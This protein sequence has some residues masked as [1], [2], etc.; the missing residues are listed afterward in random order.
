MTDDHY[1]QLAFQMY[2]YRIKLSIGFYIAA[3]GGVDVLIFTDE[4]GIQ[5]WQVR[6]KTCR[7]MAPLGIDLD[8]KANRNAAADRICKLNNPDAAV[9][10]L[11]MPTHE[12]SVIAMEGSRL[13]KAAF[14]QS[15]G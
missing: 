14:N 11:S 10:V 3:L 6:E 5:S 4:I 2:T 12:E 15:A 8:E 13:L 9:Q 7:D 1:A